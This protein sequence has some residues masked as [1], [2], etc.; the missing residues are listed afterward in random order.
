M[1]I[2]VKKIIL[3]CAAAFLTFS[4]AAYAADIP[5]MQICP[6]KIEEQTGPWQI[7]VR[8]LTV[9]PQD[10]GSVHA[11]GL[12]KLTSS[13]L[14]FQNTV[15]PELDISYF[16]TRNIAAEL[17]LG[18]TYTKINGRGKTMRGLGLDKRLGKTWILPP[19]LTLQYHF[20]NFGKFQPYIGA[21]VN[22]TFFYNE[23]DWALRN[24]TVDGTWG[25]AAQIGFDYMVTKHWGFNF[26]AK[27][28]WLN[29][30]YHAKLGKNMGELA[31]TRIT[32]RAKLDPW[33]LGA[34]I[35][36]RF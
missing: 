27:K 22:Y 29:T 11:A 25:G 17:I 23:S 2:S 9:M 16:F 3:G 13:G 31:G 7:R 35:T 30:S 12:G 36:Y 15:I 1:T 33:L 6:P 32:G 8:A 20:T 10:G 26:D 5:D 21:G 19:T 34:G 18:T 24:V 28:L 14:G 4:T